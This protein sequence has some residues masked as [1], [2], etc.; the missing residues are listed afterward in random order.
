[1]QAKDYVA[2]INAAQMAVAEA[3]IQGLE[4]PDSVLRML[5]NTFMPA[6]FQ[7]FPAALAPYE[8]VLEETNCLAE[9]SQE[10]MK[11]QY[12]LPQKLFS[13]MLGEGQLIYPKYTMA[14][15]EKGATTLEQAQE[16]MLANLVEKLDIQ[17]GDE[18][19]ELGSGWGCAANYIL[20]KFPNVQFTGLSLSHEQ[21]EYVRR[22]MQ[23]PTSYLS[24]GQFTLHEM[25]FNDAR[26]EAKFDKVISMGFF[27][28]VGNL[29]KSF[30][31]LASFLKPDGKVFTHIITVRTPNNVSSAFTHK[32]IFPYGRYW[33]Y[34]AI[35]NHSKDLKTV[36]R[37]YINGQNYFKTFDTWLQNFD[38]Y[39][40]EL[41]TLSYG[42]DYAQFRRMWRFYLLWLGTNFGC[43]DGEVNGNG[44]YLMVRA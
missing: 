15:W 16:D 35:P 31:R 3:Y 43:C 4:V 20:S 32:Y 38:G 37:W 1:M 5:F 26:F 21:C 30:Q 14:L 36:Q 42:M 23:D 41:K 27:C 11:V 28:H 40:A 19:L 34:D 33:N 12:E 17:D 29:T 39:Q 2:F 24:R 18:I 10:L 25:D 7:H 22:K 6:L 8:W 9:G 13:L 44:Q